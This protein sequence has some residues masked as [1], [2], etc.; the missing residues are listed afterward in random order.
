MIPTGNGAQRMWHKRNFLIAGLFVAVLLFGGIFI[1]VKNLYT[2]LTSAFVQNNM[3]RVVTIDDCED[4]S[5]TLDP[6]QR[7]VVEPW[8]NP[9]MG[10][11][12]Y[13]S[14]DDHGSQSGCLYF[15]SRNG[16]VIPNSI[17][18]VSNYRKTSKNCNA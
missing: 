11:T 3:T 4:Y 16:S 2:P 12:V 13:L 6:G 1:A 15:R 8:T 18:L 14:Q 9:A 7:A 17:S 5:I 10:C